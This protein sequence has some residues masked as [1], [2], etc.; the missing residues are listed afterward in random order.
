MS[1]LVIAEHEAGT[2][3]STAYELLSKASQLATELSTHVDAVVLGDAPSNELGA[4]G[5]KSVYQVSGDFS[6][7]ST[8][9]I[10]NALHAAITQSGASIVLGPNSVIARD[11]LP[12]VVARLGTGQA[13][14]CTDLRVEGGQLVG[15]RPSRAGAVYN[16]IR[17]S[18][19]PAI[20]TTRPNSF[21][22][23]VAGAGS[24]DVV[25]VDVDLGARL[26]D[27]VETRAP[28]SSAIDI[29]AAERVVA[30]GRSLKS[31]ESFDSV[32]RPLAAIMGAGT[33]ATRAAVD[34]GFAPHSEQIG[35]TGKTVS[36]KLYIAAGISGAIQHLSG[37]RTADIIVA[38]NT[39][40][41]APIFEY[42]TYGIVAD[43]FDVCPKLTAEIEALD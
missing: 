37:M 6:S 12:R 3:E 35:Q 43:L 36:P 14:E 25:A 17:I 18:K 32:I 2:F 21:E 28:D 42:A 9:Q 16:D 30:G 19:T 4:F 41:A 20:F 29:T 24:A 13:T 10:T 1:I 22:K 31:G 15:R 39:D 23:G 8:A 5:A 7:Y 26:V 33:G 38:I 34:A 40:D 27:I 11:A